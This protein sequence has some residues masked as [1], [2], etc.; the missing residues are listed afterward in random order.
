LPVSRRRSPFTSADAWATLAAASSAA[1][2]R[3]QDAELLRLGE[4]AIFRLALEPVV[5]RI[6]RSLDVLSDAAK[7]VRVASWL[8]DAGLPVTE[9][10]VTVQPIV[11]HE[12]PVTFWRLIPDSG[13]KA[14]VG[15]LARILRQLHNL[16]VPPD[17]PLPEL[18]IFGRVAERIAASPDLPATERRFLEQRLAQLRHDYADLTF[19]LPR[20]AVHGDAHQ[21]NLIRRPDGRVVLIDLERFAFGQPETDLALTATEHL[22]GWHTK[23]EY[24]EF[25]AAYGFDVTQ[26]EGFPV[27]RETYELKMTTWLMQIV[28]ESDHMAREFQIRLRSLHDRDALRR[29]QPF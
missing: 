20:S 17:L 8:R 27:L 23:A 11:V 14:T 9:P 1:G 22:V 3:G 19:P 28:R 12:H 13:I 5:V 18:D 7:E 4:N 21:Q 24:A 10:T 15:D 25:C 29:W 26:W 16:P 2:L 6:A